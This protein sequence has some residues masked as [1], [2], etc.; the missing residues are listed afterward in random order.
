MT[1]TKGG[2]IAV[3]TVISYSKSPKSPKAHMTPMITAVMD[4]KVAL[5]DLKKK[6]KMREVTRSAANMNI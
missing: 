3:S 4:I 6:K 5:N 1:I 2:M